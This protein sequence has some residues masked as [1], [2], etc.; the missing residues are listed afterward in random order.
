MDNIGTIVTIPTEVTAQT[1]KLIHKIFTYNCR[2]TNKG[3]TNNRP[4]YFVSFK[5]NIGLLEI[6][7]FPHGWGAEFS[8]GD[9]KSD[10]IKI[11]IALAPTWYS[12]QG[13]TE[14][15]IL[16][17]LAAADEIVEKVYYDWWTTI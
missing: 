16:S 15:N 5:G 3:E 10:T 14:G 13:K 8:T 1:E 17:E 11:A 12:L 9:N 2:A 6:T 7:I 4:T